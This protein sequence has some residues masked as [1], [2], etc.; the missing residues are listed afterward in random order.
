M[1]RNLPGPPGG[2]RVPPGPLGG[3]GAVESRR[4]LHV[5]DCIS[6][7][8]PKGNSRPKTF[9]A[10]WLCF[11]G[12]SPNGCAREI[13]GELPRNMLVPGEAFC[14]LSR[15]MRVPA[16]YLAR[17]LEAFL[18]GIMFEGQHN[19]AAKTNSKRQQQQTN[20][21]PTSKHRF[22]ENLQPDLISPMAILDVLCF[23]Q[24]PN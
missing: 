13:F 23:F 18:S 24:M 4:R 11:F 15:H 12:T 14:E 7:L 22:H 3:G 6:F 8:F 9:N 19:P 10:F 2:K 5:L 16:L 21:Q 20:T 17:C 1:K